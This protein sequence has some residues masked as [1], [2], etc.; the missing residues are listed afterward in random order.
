M[1]YI[2]YQVSSFLKFPPK[3][4]RSACVTLSETLIANNLNTWTLDS[5]TENLGRPHIHLLPF[6]SYQKK[7]RPRTISRLGSIF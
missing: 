1:P 6:P 5:V 2:P 3:V 4:D 7:Q